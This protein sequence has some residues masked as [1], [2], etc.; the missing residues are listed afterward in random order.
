[1]YIPGGRKELCTIGTV[2]RPSTKYVKNYLVSS[3]ERTYDITELL[4]PFN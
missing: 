4:P 1:M 3:D 2:L